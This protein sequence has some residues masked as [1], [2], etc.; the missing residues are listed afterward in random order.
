L[1]TVK[2]QNNA[3]GS[4][5]WQDAVID[6][7]IIAG[8]TFFSSLGGM[9]VMGIPTL[10]ICLPS[11]IAGATQFFITLAIKRGLREAKP[12]NTT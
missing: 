4:F 3:D 7:G 12:A 2:G 6:A 5:D 11:A 9:A 10:E 8:V 1:L